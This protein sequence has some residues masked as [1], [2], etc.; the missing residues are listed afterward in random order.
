MKSNRIKTFLLL[1]VLMF[2][3]SFGSVCSKM[4]SQ[5]A[6]L[7]PKF[8]IYYGLVMIVMVV[9]ALF[10]QQILKNLSLV[11]AYANKSITI[12]WGILWGLL[13]FNESLT[14]WKVFGSIVIIL[15]VYFVVSGEE[16]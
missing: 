14:I 16:E 9:Y 2:I 15:G 11:T 10:W 5:Q 12:I 4:A 6:I 1:H 8:I 13:L 3:Y 7:S